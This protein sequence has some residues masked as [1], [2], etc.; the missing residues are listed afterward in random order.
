MLKKLLIGI[1]ILL[2]VVIL[3]VPFGIN[4]FLWKQIQVPPEDPVEVVWTEQ[5]WQPDEWQWWYHVSQG[6]AFESIIP[7]DWFLA[8]EQPKL[9]FFR[10]APSLS[11]PKFLAGFGFL[12]NGKNTYNPDALPVGFAKAE[13]FM[14]FSTKETNTVL[15]FNCAAC[16]TGQINYQG[17]GIRIEGGEAII[18][19]DKFKTAVGLSLFLTDIVPWRFN[20]FANQVLGENATKEQKDELK[21]KLK[22]LV[23]DAQDVLNKTKSFYPSDNKEGFGRLDALDRIGNFV[24]GNQINFDNYRE[25]NAPVNYPHIWSAPWFDWVQYNGSIMQPMVRNAGEAMGVFARVDLNPDSPDVFKSNVNVENLH[26]M[27]QL[28]AGKSIFTGLTSPKWNEE[29]LGQIDYQKASQGEALYKANCQKCHLP[30][31]DS[32]E[33]MSDKYWT[34]LGDNQ[35]FE[36]L[37]VT[38]KNL[39]EIGTDPTTAINWY[40]R[41]V[42]IDTLGEKYHDEKGFEYNGIVT[43]GFALPF[44]VEKTVNEKYD[45]LNLTPEEREAFNGNRPNGIRAPLGYKARPLNG[46]WATAPFLHNGSVPNLYEMFVPASERTEKFYLGSKEFDPKFVGYNTEKIPGAFLLDTTKVGSANTGHEFK[47]DGT[48]PGVV[49]RE[50]NDDERWALVEYL[51]TL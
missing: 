5:N 13:N 24:F 9:S 51:K 20:R 32:E 31:M 14:D 34:T 2:L 7:Y 25:V 33:F 18:E 35:E 19:L 30:P 39:Y 4:Y 12:P 43:A 38:M 46:I 15:G 50:L 45:E 22:S 37:K 21:G 1:G 36:Y 27:E 47:G 42:N 3:I 44:V 8:L 17:K 11:E 26:G 16:H 6:S 41:T 49:G 28:L 23:S 10:P 40:Q 29:I 48:G